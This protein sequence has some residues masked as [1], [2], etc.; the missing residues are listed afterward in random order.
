MEK[1]FTATLKGGATS[2]VFFSLRIKDLCEKLAQYGKNSIYVFDSNTEN[3]L[4]Y[5]PE[6]SIVLPPGEKEKR[7]E[8]IDAILK[9]ALSLGLARDSVFI[10]IGGGVICDMTAFAASVY[11][12]GA[13]AVL[14]P[15]TLLSMVDASVGGKTAIDYMGLKNFVG[16]F[17]PAEDILIC[18]ETLNTLSEKE[19]LS[20]LGEVVKHAFLSQDEVLYDFMKE[21][22]GKI[23]SRD[24]S[25]MSEMVKLSL[26][27]KKYFIELDPEE[28]KGIRSFLN[29]GHTFGHALE[30]ISGYGISHGEG[31]AWGVYKAFQIGTE[32]G[33]TPKE[34]ASRSLSLLSSYPFDV[35][36]KV[37]EEDK[38]SFSDALGKDKKKSSGSVKYVL[39]EG[40]GKPVLKVIDKSSVIDIVS[41]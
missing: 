31:V 38:A 27:V 28:K 11:M 15:T 24:L 21:N 4:G 2:D 32:L 33:V 12:R 19:Y 40:Q 30:S 1:V 29:L 9:K 10:A 6:N 13:R 16:T 8:S 7:W 18:L 36:Y 17:Y 39:M 14:V 23:L 5:I 34:Y 20:G 41:N 35:S 22:R 25:A 37:S 26:Y 3:I